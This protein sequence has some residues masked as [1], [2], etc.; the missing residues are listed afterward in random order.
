MAPI[1]F[2]ENIKD[3]LENRTLQ[4]TSQAWNTL[5]N[6]LDADAKKSSKKI[7]W[8][9][10]IAASLVGILFMVN[11]FNSTSDINNS[12]SIIVNTEDQK[13]ENFQDKSIKESNLTKVVIED[14]KTEIEHLVEMNTTSKSLTNNVVVNK[15]NQINKGSITEVEPNVESE[16]V[17]DKPILVLST[18]EVELAQNENQESIKKTKTNIDALLSKAQQNLTNKNHIKS[19]SIDPDALLQDVEQDLDESFRAKVF[20]TIKTNYKRVKTAVAER[21]D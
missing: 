9:L 10:G 2:E 16:I 15:K 7:V 18:S 3:K 21:N 5:S 8:W 12:E 11:I 13:G 19:Y 6:K 20:E 17:I 4:P 1:K 14:S